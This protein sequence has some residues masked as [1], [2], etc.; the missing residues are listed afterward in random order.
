[1]AA[2]SIFTEKL[3]EESSFDCDQFIASVESSLDQAVKLQ[4]QI[5]SLP[6]IISLQKGR[7][8]LDNLRLLN[9]DVPVKLLQVYLQ[10]L[11]L[12]FSSISENIPG[13]VAT[14]K[15]L[16]EKQLAA[17]GSFT[18]TAFYPEQL[19]EEISEPTTY[20]ALSLQALSLDLPHEK[21]KLLALKLAIQNFSI[22]GV[23]DNIQ[24]LINSFVN[25]FSAI[26]SLQTQEKV[27]NLFSLFSSLCSDEALKNDREKVNGLF[28]KQLQKK[29]QAS[30]NKKKSKKFFR[31][32]ETLPEIDSI[33]AGVKWLQELDHLEQ[34]LGKKELLFSLTPLSRSI[35][36]ARI[37]TNERISGGIDAPFSYI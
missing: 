16:I 11:E 3:L 33:N 14:A 8:R 7:P 17:S 24:A 15:Q 22:S 1:M 30:T 12:F 4:R 32:L 37:T 35:N 19:L 10:E 25:L 13:F 2:L 18:Q 5:S 28:L 9:S 34:K 20:I 31:L 23:Q 36:S 6:E 21:E 29:L 27:L 26:E